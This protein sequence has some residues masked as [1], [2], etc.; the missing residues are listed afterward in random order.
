MTTRERL[1]Q[2]SSSL[3]PTRD[4]VLAWHS[5]SLKPFA[6]SAIDEGTGDDTGGRD[7]GDRSL[8]A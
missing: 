6:V 5:S 3:Q 8:S 2:D 4:S 1:S 7:K